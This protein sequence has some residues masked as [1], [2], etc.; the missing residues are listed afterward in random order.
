MAYKTSRYWGQ[1]LK[2]IADVTIEI[3]GD[4]NG[5]GEVNI[6][7]INA[8]IDIILNGELQ[9]SGDVNGDGEVNIVDVNKVIAAI[10]S[11]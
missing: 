7:D 2:I 9:L 11:D 6:A 3:P 10:L 5:D 1:F 4:V 8:V